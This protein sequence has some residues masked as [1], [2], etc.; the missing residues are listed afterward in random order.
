[1]SDPTFYELSPIMQEILQAGGTVKLKPRGIS[2]LP[3]IRP[4]MDEI[5]LRYPSQR[6]RKGDIFLYRR[7]CGKLV[8]HRLIRMKGQKL[9]FRGDNQIHSECDITKEQ[10]IG[11]ISTVRRGEK[12]IAADSVAFWFYRMVAFPCCLINR[13]IHRGERILV[14]RGQN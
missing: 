9:V 1:M 6:L 13:L 10:L 4:D 3:F 7:S 11:V 8:L 2:M 5:I 12:E 14:K